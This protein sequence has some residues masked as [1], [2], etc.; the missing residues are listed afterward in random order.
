VG[1]P[2]HRLARGHG[3]RWALAVVLAVVAGSVA[4]A[5]VQRAEQA[6]A[7][8]GEARRVPVAAADLTVG[9]ELTEGDLAWID[10][11]TG[12]VPD[13]VADTPVGRTVTEPVVRGEVLVERRL[14]GGA[15]TGP[16]DLVGPGRRALAVPAD[17]APPGLVVGDHV[18]AYAPSTS[19]GSLTDL[20]RAQGSGARRVA[21]DGLVVAVDDRSV[22]VSVAGVEAPGL[23]AALL[24][25][26]LTLALV[27]PG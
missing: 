3:L 2:L 1:S 5:T 21:R 18:E 6:R 15:T 4:A 26:A 17:A 9:T 20:A 16:A 8:Y 24:D 27:T 14:S 23:A 19:G 13:G 7:A 11:P 25:G 22:T 12:L 10:V